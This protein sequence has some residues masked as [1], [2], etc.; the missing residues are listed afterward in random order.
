MPRSATPW[1]ADWVLAALPALAEGPLAAGGG[2]GDGAARRAAVACLDLTSLDAA[3]DDAAAAALA[4][5]GVDPWGDG[6]GH[7]AAVCVHGARVPAVR[8][9]LGFA[10]PVALA[11]VCGGFPDAGQPHEVV[12]HEVRWL[13]GRDVDEVDLVVPRHLIV[14]GAWH[15]LHAWVAAVRR[16]APDV[17]LKAILGT[18]RLSLEQTVRAARVAVEAGV[19]WLK[20]CSG[21]DGDVLDVASGRALVA[22][23]AEAAERGHPVG[24][25]LSGGLRT[26]EQALGWQEE[27]AAAG[28]I[29]PER[30]RFGASSLLDALVATVAE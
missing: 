30:L 13:A 21:R 5:R 20:S 6:S 9:A 28:L 15:Q 18:G 10:S 25:K 3:T 12:L 8:A 29:G 4:R 11:A 7:V 17:S 19:D 23:A 1:E 24:V 27:A 2:L 16:A 22:V 14:D 26:V